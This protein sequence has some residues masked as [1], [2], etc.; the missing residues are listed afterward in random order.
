MN[1]TAGNHSTGDAL[2]EQKNFNVGEH[3]HPETP[4]AAGLLLSFQSQSRNKPA[5]NRR[6]FFSAAT[7]GSLITAC[8]NPPPAPTA[9]SDPI[10]TL[11]NRVRN[12]G[13]I[14]VEE[15]HRRIGRLQQRLAGSGAAGYLVEAGT[16]LEYFTGIRWGRSERLFAAIISRTG[17]PIL[18][19]P[20]FEQGRAQQQN[21]LQLD[22]RLWAEHEDPFT[23]LADTLR[24]A[25]SGPLLVEPT[26]RWWIIE[27]LRQSRPSLSLGDGTTATDHCRL[28]KSSVELERIRLANALT[29]DAFRAALAGIWEGMT[30]SQLAERISRAFSRMGV[31]GGALVLFGPNSALPHGSAVDRQLR[32][33]DVIL[34]DGGCSVSGYVSDVTRTVV[35]GEPS[36]LQA[37]LWRIVRRAQQQAIEAVRPGI[38]AG[39]LDDIA[40]GIIT[41]AGYG[42]DYAYFTHRLGHGIGMD[43]HE[44]PYLVRGNSQP[45]EPGM[46]FS[47][48]PGIYLHGQFGIRH[49][50]NV[51]VTEEGFEILG[52]PP[53]EEG[54]RV[55]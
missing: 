38:A 7:A 37:D 22:L 49:E 4:P 40:R 1:P 43:G 54:M 28:R 45:L 5:M 55:G 11:V 31:R 33:G 29:H 35:F 19:C 32:V 48:E 12:L 18:I 25:G 3:L 34:I 46:V 44:P 51:V 6:T 2:P 21:S 27:R 42:P 16:T 20:G 23:L 36:G 26:T 15:L 24:D 39:Q 47:V 14:P 9:S 53:S 8:Q 50:D 52:E 13:A 41:G 10:D 30:E 17:L